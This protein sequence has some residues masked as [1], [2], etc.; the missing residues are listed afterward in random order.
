VWVLPDPVEVGEDF[1]LRVR[2]RR[3][4]PGVSDGLRCEVVD[5]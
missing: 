1:I 2:Y 5:R 3:R 4:V